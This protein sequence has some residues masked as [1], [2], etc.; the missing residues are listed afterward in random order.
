MHTAFTVTPSAAPVVPL[1]IT[2]QTFSITPAQPS[3]PAGLVDLN[4]TNAAAIGHELLI[5]QTDLAPDKLPIGS[6]G[7]VDEGGAGVQKVFD[8]G[9]NV[10]PGKTKTFP[11]ALA[12]GHYV[13]VC[14]LPGHYAGGMH[15][16]FTVTPS[17][18]PVVPLGITLQTFSIASAQP[19]VPA[20]LVDLNVTNAA[21]I[22]HELLIFQTDLAPDKLPI[23]TDGRVDE[24]GNGIVKIFDSG[25]NVDPGKTKTFH[26]ALS[27][28][29]YVLVCNLPGHYAG[30]MHTAFTVN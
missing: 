21:T 7:R 16:A 26:T 28:G 8:S 5:F 19:G 20:G 12:A 29:H 23:G 15:T 25:A 18:A 30:G 27:A 24:G 4:V 11:I 10:D 2:L 9:A 1:G 3:V 22:G 14:N 13:L 17:A 6:D